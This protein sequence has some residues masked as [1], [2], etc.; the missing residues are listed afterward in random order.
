MIASFALLISLLG[1]WFLIRYRRA[2]G[3]GI[4]P[5]LG[6]ALVWL[7]LTLS[8]PVSLWFGATISAGSETEALMEGSPINRISDTI[9]ILI[10]LLIICK[11]K[12]SL[13][14]FIRANKVLFVLLA[15][16]AISILWSDFP[17]V[18]LKR[19]SRHL[20]TIIYV[21]VVLTDPRGFRAVTT[22]IRYVPYILL[23][24]SIILFKW[25][26]NLGRAYDSIGGMQITGVT[27]SRNALGLLCMVSALFLF[28]EI[29]SEWSSGNRR[30]LILKGDFCLFCVAIWVLFVCNSATSL[31]SFYVGIAT[32]LAL[33]SKRITIM[34]KPGVFLAALAFT[35]AM[36]IFVSSFSGFIGSFV[37]ITGHSD[38]FWGRTELWKLIIGLVP[39]PLLGCGY[40]SFWLGERLESLW[41][42]YWWKPQ[43]AHNGFVGVYASLGL[44][45][46]A[47][48]VGFFAQS[49]RRLLRSLA[50]G[51]EFAIIKLAFLTAALFYNITEYAFLGM[52]PVWFLCL[53]V[54]VRLG[55]ASGHVFSE[56]TEGIEELMQVE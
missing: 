31:F 45:G 39:N 38:T 13:T 40:D 47:I 18:A 37:G 53:L 46:V 15:Y 52:Q 32:Y 25:F 49:F 28:D 35:V 7:L 42:I 34:R 29:H 4:G 2:E 8:R 44:T 20:V 5:E 41:K 14:E 11:R 19:W 10:G 3:E 23:P 43:E 17:G 51:D 12:P 26:S 55:P 54:A 16:C 6:V 21:L 36:P 33:G 30:S 48:L 9:F 22:M 50:E 27:T 24:L 56:T 1:W